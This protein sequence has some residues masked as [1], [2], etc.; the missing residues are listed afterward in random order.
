MSITTSELKANLGA[1]SSEQLLGRRAKSGLTEAAEAVIDQLLSERGVTQ[2]QKAIVTAQVKATA[3]KEEKVKSSLASLGQR[4]GGQLIDTC[5]AF[6]FL[7]AGVLASKPGAGGAASFGALVFIA[8]L[9]L[10]D[11]MPNGQ[12][13][14]KK[15]VGIRVVD[16]RTG[17]SCSILQSAGRNLLLLILGVIDWLFILGPKHQRLGDMA[18]N[19]VVVKVRAHT[20]Q[21]SVQ[22]D[23]PAS[24]GSAA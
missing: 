7:F 1:L 16:A 3:E 14:G 24:G 22:A 17:N 2:E 20:V 12:S 6:A 5:I 23:G 21:P 8:Y 19:T 4:L 11:A 15:L 9:L 18:A 10:A 13:W